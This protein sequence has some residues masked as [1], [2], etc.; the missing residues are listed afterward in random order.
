[1]RLL[2]ILQFRPVEHLRISH[3]NLTL[4]T[5][6]VIWTSMCER[7]VQQQREK[8]HDDWAWTKGKKIF[9]FI[10]LFNFGV[11]SWPK[12]VW[13]CVSAVIAGNLRFKTQPNAIFP[14]VSH[15]SRLK[16]DDEIVFTLTKE[17]RILYHSLIFSFNISNSVRDNPVRGDSVPES[18]RYAILLFDC[19]LFCNTAFSPLFLFT[20]CWK[21]NKRAQYS[22][23][24]AQMWS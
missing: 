5:N 4:S 12:W 22:I 8:W 2:Y 16:F 3:W 7:S 1:M 10:P 14:F 18:N 21:E 6:I 20:L 17:K 23:H 11:F 15:V 19:I 9:P 24:C 13:N